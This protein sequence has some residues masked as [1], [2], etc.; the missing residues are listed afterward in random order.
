M[1]QI[2]Y[3]I[4]GELLK[5]PNHIRGLAK[6]LKTNQMTISRK[7]QELYHSKAVDFR[8]EGRNKVFYLA[9]TLEAKQHLY[10]YEHHKLLHRMQQ[11]PRLRHIIEQVRKNPHI[12][13]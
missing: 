9:K 7:I 8:K 11:Y 1:S 12:H 5:K 2:S 4:I 13:L 6:A 3:N 10:I